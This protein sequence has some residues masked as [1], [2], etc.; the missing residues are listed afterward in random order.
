[1]RLRLRVRRWCMSLMSL[2]ALDWNWVDIPTP[3]VEAA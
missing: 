3:S 1:M 2:D